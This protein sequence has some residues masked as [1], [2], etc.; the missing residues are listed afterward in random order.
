[1]L[2]GIVEEG[3]FADGGLEAEALIE[4][5]AARVIEDVGK[6]VGEGLEAGAESGG[7]FGDLF[8]EFFASDDFH[9]LNEADH[10][11]E[12]AA[13]GAVQDSAVFHGK[14]HVDDAAAELFG[15]GDGLRGVGK[16]ELVDGPEGSGLTS[17]GL[18]F[19]EAEEGFVAMGEVAE[20]LEKPGEGDAVA[21][22][23]LE[24]FDD[25]AGDFVTE[26][27]QDFLDNVE[28]FIGELLVF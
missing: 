8:D 6:L 10:V 4:A 23:A 26:H 5:D 25:D 15:G 9:F 20:R 27:L 2:E 24:R 21:A 14:E 7:F 13:P 17:G 3:G 16:I 11:G 12:V 1:M 18:D 19:V 28:A 22:G